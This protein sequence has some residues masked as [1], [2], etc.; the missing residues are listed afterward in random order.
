MELK[1]YLAKNTDA[2]TSLFDR[3][4][5]AIASGDAAKVSELQIEMNGKMNILRE[6][7]R[8][9]CNNQI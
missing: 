7:Y 9:Y 1:E 3:I 5:E 6:K 8:D 2:S 4:K